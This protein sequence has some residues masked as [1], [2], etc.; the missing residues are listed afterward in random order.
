M[1]QITRDKD[2]IAQPAQ[3]V[4]D[5]RLILLRT[6]DEAD[7][8]VLA[9][10]HL[11]G[12][13]VIHV[14]VHGPRVLVAEVTKHQVNGDETLLAPVVEQQVNVV[15]LIVKSNAPLAGDKA[16]AFAHFQ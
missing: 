8:R 3:R 1:Q 15:V 12:L 14:E 10:F 7:G 6:Q 13:Q 4:F 2:R 5:V 16:E 9:L 11:F